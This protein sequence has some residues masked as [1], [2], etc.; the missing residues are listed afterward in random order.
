MGL[1]TP[2]YTSLTGL[3]T[4]SEG[5]SV[6]G[7]N[8]ANVNSTGFKSS[9]ISFETHISR[10]LTI[11]EAPS[12]ALGGVN[13]AQIGLGAKIASIDRDF[14]NG[15]I[16]PS[17]INTDLAIDGN[18]FFVLDFDGV[19]RFSRAG[20]FT[21]DRDFDLVKVGDGGRL[22]GFGIDAAF[23]VIEG[24]VEDINI[25]IGNLTVAEATQNAQFSGN[26]NADG[27]A[28]TTG[29]LINSGQL[30]SDVGATMFA[31]AATTLTSLF[32]GSG[33]Q[34][35]M[36]ADVLTM[37]D[38]DKGGATVPTHTFQVGAANTTGS[39]DFGT[40]V[41]DLLD[42]MDAVLGIDANA[43][44]SAGVSVNGTGQIVIR[45]NSGTVNDITIDNDDLLVNQATNPTRPFT[46]TKSTAADGESV[47]TSFVAFDSLGTAMVLDLSFVLESK[48]N[49]GT[50]WRFYVQS[51]DDTD[52]D[53]VLSTGTTSYDTEGQFL[54]LINPSFTIDRANTGAAT[55][56]QITLSFNDPAGSLS[57]LTDARS[58]VAPTGQ[59]GSP[60]G[61]LEDFTTEV[62]GTIVGVFSNGEQRDLG[63]V[64]LA[65]FANNDGLI[66][67]G[68]NIFDPSVNSGT[69][70]IVTPG[71][72]GSGRIIGSA[73][74]LS[75]VE[76]SREF[77]NLIT[78]ST[79][80]A[81][82]S[83]VITTTDRMIQELLASTR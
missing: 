68:D 22:Q 1:T 58:E 3:T 55:P 21:F 17:G 72:A 45:G 70:A 57:A 51:E 29:A 53:R 71:S 13:P 4:S 20:N 42:F 43:D 37:M 66:E 18:G 54:N 61:T 82:N 83:R 23:N 64:V 75:N 52:L 15:V 25:P 10:T 19:Q 60:I 41:Q 34:L 63:R 67:Q 80:F 39:D 32:D 69:A 77:I 74:E 47:R 46:F 38:V 44:V 35:F 27:D 28:A 59:D 73:L 48:T 78:Y 31:T 5:I 36:D 24:T 79:G 14:S 30:F 56:Q 49:T 65:M 9:R 12:A 7:N 8:L 50:Q 6:T 76:L 16:Q 81:A 2:L 62:D 26:L 40:L 33:I 11:G